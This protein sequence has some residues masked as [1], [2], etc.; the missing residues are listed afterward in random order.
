MS[1]ESGSEIRLAASVSSFETA[2]VYAVTSDSEAEVDFASL[3]TA[4]GL[5]HLFIVL[6]PSAL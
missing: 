6:R 4:E 2:I 1:A 3:V 5:A